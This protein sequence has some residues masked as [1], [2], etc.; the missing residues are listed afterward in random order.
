[1]KKKGKNKKHNLSLM[2]IHKDK[3]PTVNVLL[4]GIGVIYTLIILEFAYYYVN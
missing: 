3:L 2:G 4:I 1:M